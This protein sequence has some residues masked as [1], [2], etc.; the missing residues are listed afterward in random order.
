M[1]FL[2]VL[3]ELLGAS[4]STKN[5][6]GIRGRATPE[7]R[8]QIREH[9]RR[10]REERPARAPRERPVKK[11]YNDSSVFANRPQ[12]GPDFIKRYKAGEI[13]GSPYGLIGDKR[14][15]DV[16][17]VWAEGERA[18]KALRG[19]DYSSTGASKDAVRKMAKTGK[20]MDIEGP[21]KVASIKTFYEDD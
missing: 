19:R 9:N 7:Q 1:S 8:A 11:N 16:R 20:L 12:I 3:K 18:R 21:S 13:K 15:R 5:I 14:K 2:D 17:S 10:D 4:E 6:M